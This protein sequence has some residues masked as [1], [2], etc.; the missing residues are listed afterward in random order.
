M[1]LASLARGAYVFA[2]KMGEAPPQGSRTLPA[3]AGNAALF[4]AFALHHSIAAR[5]TVKRAVEHLVGPCLERASFVWTAS[6]LFTLAVSR[7]HRVPGQIYARKGPAAAA[8]RMAQLA[9]V[10]LTAWSALRLDP[11]ELAG[12]ERQHG[13]RSGRPRM[14]IAT[15]GPYAF[16]R[17][18]IYTG[19]IL[20]VFGTPRMTATRL[21]FASLSTL[22]LLLAMPL[23]E[24]SL[25]ARLG[26]R[27]RAY[28]DAVR[29]RLVPF[30]Y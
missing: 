8:H 16:V 1:F 15:R 19:W 25:E 11:L 6:I 20:M 22:Y 10:G 29:Y 17:H 24:R 21:V 26:S 23:E 13:D 7:W 2:K 3:V 28:S 27:Y 30:L 12:I 9:G 18:P 14:V 4:S 5:P